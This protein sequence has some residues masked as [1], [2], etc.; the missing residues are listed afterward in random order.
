MGG[1]STTFFGGPIERDVCHVSNENR[2]LFEAF[3]ESPYST[4]SP[5]FFIGVQRDS[6]S[7]PRAAIPFPALQS[8]KSV[9]GR[10]QYLYV[11][12]PVGGEKEHRGGGT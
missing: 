9:C 5:L 6:A 7:S 8:G 11:H 4:A 10:G 2:G 3:Y 12:Y 1:P